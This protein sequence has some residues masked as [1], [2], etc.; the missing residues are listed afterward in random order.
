MQKR[1][2]SLEAELQT[3]QKEVEELSAVLKTAQSAPPSHDTP[4]LGSKIGELES[5]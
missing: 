5:M 1:V 2:N 4:D 3:S